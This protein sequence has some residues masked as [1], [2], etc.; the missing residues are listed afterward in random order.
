MAYAIVEW[1]KQICIDVIKE[2]EKHQCLWNVQVE[3][4]QNAMKKKHTSYDIGINLESTSEDVE[5]KKL[6]LC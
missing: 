1:N 5:K 3:E 2:F 6:K 4:Y